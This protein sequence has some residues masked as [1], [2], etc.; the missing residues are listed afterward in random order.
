MDVI[1][2]ARAI[3]P[4]IAT[5]APS[6]IVGSNNPDAVKLLQ[7]M[8]ETGQEIARRADWGA[9]EKTPTVSATGT[10]QTYALPSDFSRLSLGSAVTFNGMPV[11]GGLSRD[12]AFALPATIGTPR[13]FR[14]AGKTI[15]F[16]PHPPALSQVLVSYQTANWCFN[17]GTGFSADDDEPLI[18]DELM[19][20]GTIW[21]W[22][23][24]EGQD[25][26]DFL[27]EY[28]AMLEQFGAF[29]QRERQP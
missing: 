13:Y 6:V 21:R 10:A 26:S 16:Y 24:S 17:G 4:S 3:A 18:P 11:R 5:P 23:R 20:R 22:K 29:D 25:F 14:L 27:A 19:T 2:L 7:L 9:L 15:R 8:N 1:E 28:E 12:E